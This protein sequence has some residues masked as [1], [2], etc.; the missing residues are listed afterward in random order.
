S[1]QF[2]LREWTTTKPAEGRVEAAATGVIGGQNLRGRLIRAAVQVNADFEIVVALHNG[3]NHL[4]NL[5]RRCDPD[6]IGE[7]NHVNILRFEQIDSSDHFVEV[8]RIAIR[9]A[10]GHRY[11]NDSVHTLF[12]TLFLDL[13]QFLDR[14]FES[15]A[16]VILQKCRRNRVWETE[17][18]DR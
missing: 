11:V 4:A 2:V 16:L 6:R 7:R 12:I 15:L 17:R 14:V 3:R 1:Y 18:A 5:L 13:L 8:P 9:I 10:E